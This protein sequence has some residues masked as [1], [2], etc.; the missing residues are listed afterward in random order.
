[1]LSGDFHCVFAIT[2]PDEW[3][4]QQVSA[5]CELLPI[6]K[7]EEFF[8]FLSGS[9]IVVLDGYHF[10]YA[11]QEEVRGQG[12]KLVCIDDLHHRRFSAEVIIN[13][14]P[15]A[16]PE[17]Y[18]AEPYTQFC[19]GPDYALLRPAFLQAMRETVNL[20]DKKEALICFGGSDFHNITVKSVREIKQADGLEK[21]HALVGSAYLYQEELEELVKSSSETEVIIHRGLSAEEMVDLMRKCRLALTSASSILFEVLALRIPVICGYYVDNQMDIY[22]GFK[23]LGLIDAVGDL[24]EDFDLNAA[25]GRVLNMTPEELDGFKGLSGVDPRKNYR[26]LFASL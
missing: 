8:D 18:T 6:Q 9:E 21:V 12:C 16:N 17:D 2:N 14:A 5:V 10:D 26:N 20:A 1:M 7:E 22:N 24:R 3:L 19:F 13:H 25:V 23:S 4:S 11:Y 15:G